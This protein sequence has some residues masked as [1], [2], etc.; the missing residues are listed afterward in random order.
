MPLSIRRTQRLNINI[1]QN[2]QLARICS[3]TDKTHRNSLYEPKERKK[4]DHL[5]APK[6]FHAL[7]KLSTIFTAPSWSKEKHKIINPIRHEP[8]SEHI[9]NSGTASQIA[10]EQRRQCK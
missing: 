8:I 10:K 5:E 7:E 6:L 9:G 1:C 3:Q 2:Q 4:S